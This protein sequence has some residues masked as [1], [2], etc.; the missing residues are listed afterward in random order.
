MSRTTIFVTTP[1]SEPPVQF[2]NFVK[3]LSL[4]MCW[5]VSQLKQYTTSALTTKPPLSVSMNSDWCLN[6]A[7][8]H[9]F[10]YPHF[11]LNCTSL[12]KVLA[13]HTPWPDPIG[14]MLG[15]QHTPLL[16][17]NVST[18]D[19]R[20]K[21]REKN[22]TLVSWTHT[23]CWLWNHFSGHLSGNQSPGLSLLQLWKP[24]R[25][26]QRKATLVLVGQWN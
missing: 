17:W 16:T 23:G 24:F 3:K 25:H 7:Q 2:K 21:E 26:S 10:R 11:F 13:F 8:Y 22:V 12:E 6:I 20:F 4:F 9:C 19:K 15:Y 1:P 5:A 14:L 18:K